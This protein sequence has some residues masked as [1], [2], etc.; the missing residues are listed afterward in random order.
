MVIYSEEDLKV[1]EIF[2]QFKAEGSIADLTI[3]N[4][5]IALDLRILGG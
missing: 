4:G 3:S 1:I 2:N 5:L